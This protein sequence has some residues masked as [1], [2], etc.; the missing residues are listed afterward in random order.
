[1]NWGK[2]IV[3]VYVLFVIGIGYMVYR[4]TQENFEMV[5]SNYY[6]KELEYSGKM[7]AKANAEKAGKF[8]KVIRDNN[9]VSLLIPISKNQEISGEIYAYCP[10]ASKND[11]KLAIKKSSGTDSVCLMSLNTLNKAN[12]QL[13]ITWKEGGDEY[14][15]EVTFDR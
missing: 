6:Q 12:Y 7:V 11:R 1:M 3:V 5:D 4:S 9:Q 13:K 15:S 2:S 14:Y 8:P 10:S